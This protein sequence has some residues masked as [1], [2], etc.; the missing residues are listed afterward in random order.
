MLFLIVT[1]GISCADD[2]GDPEP[3]ETGPFLFIPAPGRCEIYIDDEVRGIAPLLITDLAAGLHRLEAR[4]ATR[5]GRRSFIVKEDIDA[6]TSF[7]PVME[8]YTG[9]LIVTSSP[10]NMDILLNGEKAGVT[11]VSISGIRTGTCTVVLQQEGYLPVEETVQIS[12]EKETSLAI[13]M[14]E[15]YRVTFAPPLPGNTYISVTDEAGQPFDTGKDHPGE[16]LILPV[17]TWNITI[18]GETFHPVTRNITVTDSDLVLG[19]EPDPYYGDIFLSGLDRTSTVFL[20]GIDV[21]EQIME[22]CIRI[23]AGFHSVSIETKSYMPFL[24]EFFLGKD[25]NLSIV[26]DM[27]K[28]AVYVRKRKEGMGIPVIISGLAIAAGGYILNMD[29]LAMGMTDTYEEYVTLKYSTLG[30]LGTGL[31]LSSIGG[32]ILLTAP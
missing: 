29:S 15:A 5:V 14:I 9:T 32:L 8:P 7:E 13:T 17:G 27:L 21:T 6:V 26:P 19:L 4:S 30:A 24:Q 10:G 22:G 31:L 25:E 1:A 2:T 11:P 23:P 20:D 18:S 16:G 3:L 12:W 28:D